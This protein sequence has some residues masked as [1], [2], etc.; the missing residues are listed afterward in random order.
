MFERKNMD[1]TKLH[2]T[3]NYFFQNKHHC[4]D[5]MNCLHHLTY[6]QVSAKTGLNIDKTAHSN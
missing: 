3:G 2:V 1:R 6:V 4:K 5:T